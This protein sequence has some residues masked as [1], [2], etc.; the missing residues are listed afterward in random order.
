MAK[1]HTET[2][3][4]VALL[5]AHVLLGAYYS[6]VIPV[7][8]AHDEDGHFFFVRYLASERHLPLPGEKSASKNDE[9]HQP[10]LYYILAALPVGL[11]GVDDGLTPKYNATMSWPDG[12]GGRNRVVHDAAAEAWPYRGT[13]LAIHLA[14][15]V[16]VLLGAAGLLFTFLAARKVFP[17]EPA[18][19]WGAVLLLAFW[20]QYRFSTAVI[21]N[22]IMVTMCGAAVTWLL[23]V[24]IMGGRPRLWALLAML[25]TA[26]LAVLSKGNGLALLPVVLMVLLGCVLSAEPADRRRLL[27]RLGGGLAAGAIAV[28]LWYARNLRGGVGLFGG[29]RSVGLLWMQVVEPFLGGRQFPWHLVWPALKHGLSSLWAGFGWNNVGLPLPVYSAAAVWGALGL[30]G[31]AL[32]LWRRPPRRLVVALGALMLVI[33]PTVI[34]A[35]LLTVPMRTV[36]AHGRSWLPALPAI[37]ILLSVGWSTMVPGRVRRLGWGVTAG[38]LG[39]L[40]VL[41]PVLYIRPAYAMPKQLSADQ[42]AGF[43][44]V[45]ATFGGFAELVGYRI[46]DRFVEPDG[47]VRVSLFWRVLARAEADYTLAIQAFEGQHTMVGEVQRLPGQGAYATTTWQPGTLYSEDVAMR[48]QS[49]EQG[50]HLG[51]LEVSFFREKGVLPV[52]VV[53]GNGGDLGYSVRLGRIKIRKEA[54]ARPVAHV[55]DG[56]RFGAAILLRGGEARLEPAA[57]GQM[58]ALNLQWLA[59]GQQDTDYTVSVQLRD[60]QQVVVDQADDQPGHGAYPTSFWEV[61][62]TIDDEYTLELPPNLGTSPYSVYVCM[63]DLATMRRL[64]VADAQGQPSPHEELLVLTLSS[65]SDGRVR[66]HSSCPSVSTA[67]AWCW[68]CSLAA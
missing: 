1:R 33:I 19:R 36:T 51:W 54:S 25:G 24:N 50:A 58:L 68:R 16:S 14:R 46:D 15:L 39:L 31:C 66:L 21:N 61:G 55:E 13:T 62:E 32:W 17:L 26:A 52:S 8:E 23:A 5:V 49:D 63:Y 30:A 41:T 20:P 48:L 44:P 7:Y 2:W 57:G 65:D 47:T 35:L 38:A 10:P 11:A 18:V 22:D 4:L 37:C 53:D 34:M 60:T 42:A 27:I 3:A 59:V 43:T 56:V 29:D 12:Q 28:G 64:P 9:M 40:A 45:H 6:M 67:L